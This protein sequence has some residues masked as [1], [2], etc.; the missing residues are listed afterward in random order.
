MQIHDLYEDLSPEEA[1]FIIDLYEAIKKLVLLDV[2]ITLVR[3]GFE[4]NIQPQELAD[5]I[6]IIVRIL[7]LVEI[8]IEIQ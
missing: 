2:D 5:Y 8:E 3:L 7:D 4:L 1:D 6:G